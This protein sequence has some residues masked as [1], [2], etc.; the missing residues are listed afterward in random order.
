VKRG[1]LQIAIGTEGYCPAYAGHLRKKLD[2]TFT[3]KHGEFL[4][5]LEAA[6]KRIL[7]DVPDATARKT[8]LGELVDDESFEY[9]NKNGPEAWRDRAESIVEEHKLK[10]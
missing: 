9:F 5:E 4:A 2:Q 10:A 6:R 3:D 7:L 1:D 8:V